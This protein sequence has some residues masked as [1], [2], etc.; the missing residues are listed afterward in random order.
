MGKG[1]LKRHFADKTSEL[2]VQVCTIVADNVLLGV[3]IVIE[4]AFENYVVPG[5]PLHSELSRVCFWVFRIIF[6][7][8]TL[9]PPLV[10]LY[11]DVRTIWM[12]AQASIK[13][14][15]RALG[16]DSVGGPK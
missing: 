6:A 14:E 10:F 9:C 7:F 3:W 5:F 12:R 8:S 13:T 1:E 16:V 15:A 4:S 2:G 11:R